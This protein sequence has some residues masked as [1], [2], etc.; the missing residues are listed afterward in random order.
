MREINLSASTEKS[1]LISARTP[2]RRISA[3]VFIA[4]L[5]SGTDEVYRISDLNPL[6][7]FQFSKQ[8]LVG[9][10][11]PHCTSLYGTCHMKR[12]HW[13]DANP[14]SFSLILRLKNTAH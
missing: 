12:I 6:V 1:A 2:S 4:A 10:Q 13:F 3:S 11:K 5:Q 7:V 8:S 14:D 9:G